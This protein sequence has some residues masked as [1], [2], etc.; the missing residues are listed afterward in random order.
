MSEPWTKEDT[1]RWLDDFPLPSDFVWPPAPAADARTVTPSHRILKGGYGKW[2]RE[3]P[4][5]RGLFAQVHEILAA[6]PIGATM[7][8]PVELTRRL[9]ERGPEG[10]LPLEKAAEKPDDDDQPF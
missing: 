3:T 6:V 9:M 8:S 2:L 4:Y 5:H 10:D 7:P 1:E